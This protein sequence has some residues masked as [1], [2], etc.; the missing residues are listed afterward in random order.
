MARWRSASL[1]AVQYRSMATVP[2][3]K[4]R[5]LCDAKG[6]LTTLLIGE[7]TMEIAPEFPSAMLPVCANYVHA[8]SSSEGGENT[9]YSGPLG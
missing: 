8:C 4:E 9:I 6:Y 5:M 2:E 7:Y 1:D 3:V